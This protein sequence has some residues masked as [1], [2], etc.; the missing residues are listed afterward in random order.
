MF[1]NSFDA[2]WWPF[3]FIT[4]AGV[5]PTMV[6]RWAGALL[7]GN[8]DE[9]SQG[10]LFV[11]C[12]ATSLVAAVIAQFVFYPNGALSEI[13]ML[14]RASAALFGFAVFLRSGQKLIWGILS[15]EAV[16]FLGVML[17]SL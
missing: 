13:P 8:L 7:V 5:L 15:A 10:L 11:R 17:T 3:V 1:Y 4:L 12:L 14:V 9:D 6:W 16:L 2:W